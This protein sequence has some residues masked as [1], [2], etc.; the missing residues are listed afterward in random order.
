VGQY[1]ASGFSSLETH[2]KR[3]W[4]IASSARHCIADRTTG[5]GCIGCFERFAASR[6]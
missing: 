3:A 2:R 5:L 1:F 4:R 6:A